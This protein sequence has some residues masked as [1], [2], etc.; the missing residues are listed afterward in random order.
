MASFISSSTPHCGLHLQESSE[1]FSNDVAFALP[2][3]THYPPPPNTSILLDSSCFT[4]LLSCKANMPTQLRLR[5][6]VVEWKG[7][8]RYLGVHFDRSLR[9]VLHVVL[10]IQMSYVA[11][12]KLRP[13]LT[14]YRK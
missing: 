1:A 13:I 9:M 14:S 5:G 7:C 8:I 11:R 6:Q 12:T 2:S 10:V 4:G 3:T